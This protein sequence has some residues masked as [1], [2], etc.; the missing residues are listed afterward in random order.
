MVWTWPVTQGDLGLVAIPESNLLPSKRRQQWLSF[1]CMGPELHYSGLTASTICIISKVPTLF[2][3]TGFLTK[4]STCRLTGLDSQQAPG[5]PLSPPPSS[6]ILQAYC[7]A[8]Q[9]GTG[10]L[11][12]DTQASAISTFSTGPFPQCHAPAWSVQI[13]PLCSHTS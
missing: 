10:D 7:R 8:F 9:V 4:H 12:A 13:V 3:E 5:I 11:N 1:H 2:W 6:G